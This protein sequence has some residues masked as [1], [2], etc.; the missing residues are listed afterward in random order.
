[1]LVVAAIVLAD[2]ITG[3]SDVRCATDVVSQRRVRHFFT[4]AG[5]ITRYLRECRCRGVFH[6]ERSSRATTVTAVIGR[7]EGHSS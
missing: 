5:L 2:H 4:L 7:R 3:F 6:A 1:M